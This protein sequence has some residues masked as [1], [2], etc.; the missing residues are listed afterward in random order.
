MGGQQGEMGSYD[1]A[2]AKIGRWVTKTGDGR[3]RQGN[4]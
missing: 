3:I 4:G 2:M 1:R